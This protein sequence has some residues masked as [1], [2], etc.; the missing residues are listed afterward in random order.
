MQVR[1]IGFIVSMSIKA[2]FRE[3]EVAATRSLTE[4]I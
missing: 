3:Q 1:F 4:E 2:R